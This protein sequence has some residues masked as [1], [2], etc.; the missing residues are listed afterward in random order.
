MEKEF[1]RKDDVDR[2]LKEKDN[3]L[4][5]VITGLRKVGKSYLL[6][7]LFKRKLFGLGV[8]EDHII[9]AD[10]ALDENEGLLDRAKLRSYIDSRLR[11]GGHYYLILDEIQEVDGFEK[12]LLS[13]NAKGNVDLYVTGSNSHNLS[14][15][16]DTRLRGSDSQIHLY[17]IS[18]EEYLA[19]SSLEREAALTQYL[20]YGG[21]PLAL[22]KNDD[23]ERQSYLSNLFQTT[24]LSDIEGRHGIRNKPSFERLCDILSSTVGSLTNPKVLEDTFKTYHFNLT[25]DTIA[26]YLSYLKDSFLFEEC[27][28]YD[29]KGKQYISTPAK[30]YC[31]DLGL[32]NARLAMRDVEYQQLLENVIYLELRR[33]GCL[34]DVGVVPVEI[35]DPISKARTYQSYEIDFVVNKG[36]KKVYLQ[37]AMD[38]S[39]SGKEAQE[40]R[41]FDHTGDHFAKFVVLKEPGHPGGFDEKGH[42]VISLADFLLNKDLI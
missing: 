25:N 4:I 7:T 18:F 39:K 8:A 24:Y 21:M 2:L 22:L 12:L 27:K 1:P 33:R 6:S 32:R 30:Y 16:I 38:L 40:T 31:G 15:D 13:Y 37:A 34:V 36:N 10:L 35:I 28:R 14:S 20:R 29:V 9:S 26:L 11:D 41:S 3:H 19:S 42:F 23:G 5:K 17:P